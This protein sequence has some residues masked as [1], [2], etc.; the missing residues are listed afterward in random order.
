M[1]S[2]ESLTDE[3][4]ISSP[5]KRFLDWIENSFMSTKIIS[6]WGYLFYQREIICISTLK[7]ESGTSK[8]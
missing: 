7:K 2:L 3:V 8:K 4:Y 6:L 1:A 5:R